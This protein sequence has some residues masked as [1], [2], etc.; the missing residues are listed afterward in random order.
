[1]SLTCRALAAAKVE[2]STLMSAANIQ[3]DGAYRL[4]PGYA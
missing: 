3:R 4:A 2:R 1:M